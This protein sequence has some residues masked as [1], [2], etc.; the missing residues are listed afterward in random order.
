M[1]DVINKPRISKW[2]GGGYFLLMLFIALLYA[3]I[4]SVS[5]FGSLSAAVTLNVIMLFAFALIAVTVYGFYKTT[6]VIKDGV[7]SAWSPFVV[8]NLKVNDITKVEQTR[9]PFYFKGFGAGLYSG[10]FYIPGIGWT[11]VIITNLTDGLL[12]TDRKGKH[13]LI[14]PSNPGKFLKK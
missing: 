11:R 14:T 12:I 8:I 3:F 9:I 2:I 6:Y 13:Y 10:M 4:L 7:L 5:H 1:K